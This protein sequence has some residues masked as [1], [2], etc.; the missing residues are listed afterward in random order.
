MVLEETCD[1]G[2]CG[3]EC[4]IEGCFD[5]DKRQSRHVADAWPDVAQ[6]PKA[7]VATHAGGRLTAAEDIWA[8]KAYA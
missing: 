1:A 4:A 6:G 8:S 7:L 3:S 2:A 5:V